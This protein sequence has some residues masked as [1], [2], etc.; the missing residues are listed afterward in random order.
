MYILRGLFVDVI[1]VVL[2]IDV[3]VI[4]ALRVFYVEIYQD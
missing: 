3:I 4:D 1:D 2:V